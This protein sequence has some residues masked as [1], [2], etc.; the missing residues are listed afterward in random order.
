VVVGN[1]S[2]ELTKLKGKSRIFF[3]NGNYANGIL[4][5]LNH[6]NFLSDI[7]IP[8]EVHPTTKR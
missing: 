7:T 8:E 1:H 6:Y 2:P 5:G 3:A 4:E